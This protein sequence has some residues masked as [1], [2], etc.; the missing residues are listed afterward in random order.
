M[1]GIFPKKN[2]SANMFSV[3]LA[4]AAFGVVGFVLGTLVRSPW[5]WASTAPFRAA[6]DQ[7]E[8]WVAPTREAKAQL[9]LVRA[10]RNLSEIERL[11]AKGD[12]DDV[13][14]ESRDIRQ[15]MEKVMDDVFEI[16]A[17]GRDAD[18]LVSQAEAILL[19]LETLVSEAEG[20]ASGAEKDLLNFELSLITA[21]SVR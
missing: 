13:A 2:W 1:K 21:I 9:R 12:F 5:L 15:G 3:G 7:A 18:D 4:F 10:R 8:N 16:R 11:T 19:E 6:E 20:L 17:A 14:E